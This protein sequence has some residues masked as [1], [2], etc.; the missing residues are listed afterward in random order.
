MGMLLI[1][2]LKVSAGE[3][4][5]LKNIN[6][7]VADGE[8]VV[9][10]GPN[11]SGKTTLLKAIMGLSSCQVEEG[12]MFF[13]DKLINKLKVDE[14][15]KL[16]IGMSFQRAPKVSGVKINQIVNYFNNPDKEKIINKFKMLHL[17]DRDL[18]ENLSGGEIKRSELMQ[19]KMQ[20]AQLLLLDEPDSGVD[21]ENVAMIGK[22]INNLIK[23]GKSGI[24]ITHT[25]AILDYV[26]SNRAYVLVEGEIVCSGK[27]KSI[28]KTINANGYKSCIKCNTKYGESC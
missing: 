20:K 19:L 6:L 14:R 16:G 2:K 23:D 24:L 13:K 21:I 8:L 26:K 22:E 28:L 4:E 9:V 3:K 27:T 18:N 7:T 17:V 11:G 25:G 15:A 10:F 5:V 12:K 1:E